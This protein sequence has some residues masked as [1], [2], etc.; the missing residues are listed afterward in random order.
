MEYKN[1]STVKLSM[2]VKEVILLSMILSFLK[3]SRR[4]H[5]EMTHKKK[6]KDQIVSFQNTSLNNIEL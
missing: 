5:K 1:Q 3:S 2:Q 6:S 4:T